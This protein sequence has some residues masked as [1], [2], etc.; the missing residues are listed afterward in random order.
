MNLIKKEIDLNGKTM[1]IETGW[2]AK[3]ANGSAVVRY[4]DTMV[5]VT[6]CASKDAKEGQDFFPLQVEY[7]ER[8]YAAGKIPGGFFKRESRPSEKEILTARCTDRPIRPCFP[9]G[10]L[11]EVQVIVHVISQDQENDADVLAIVGAGTVLSISDIPFGKPV[12]G[13]RVCLVDDQYVVNPTFEQVERSTMDMIVAGTADSI[14]MVEGGSFEISEDQMLKGIA[15][16][17]DAIKKI[18]AAEAELVRECG[19]PKF[20]Y[21]PKTL[22][23]VL[24][25]KVRE[26]SFARVQQCYAIAKKEDR[27]DAV[28]A[29]KK[30]V[31]EKLAAEYPEGAKDIKEVIHGLESDVMRESILSKGVRIDGRATNVIRPIHCQVGVLPRAHGSAL[32]TRGETQGL[33]AATLGTKMDE[34]KIDALHGESWKDYMFHYNFP[35]FC[36]GEVKPIRGTGRREIGHGHLAERSLA[37]VLPSK[38]KFPY[39]IRVVS[40]ILESN[41]S[42]SMASVCGGSLSLMDAGVPLKGPVAGIAMGL[43]KEGDQIAILSDI[44]GDEDHLGDMDF[45]VTGTKDGITAFQ[46][47]IKIAGITPDIMLRALHQARDGR[48]HILGKMAEAIHEPRK[49]LSVYAPRIITL[50][51]GVEEIG[52]IIG[53]QGKVIKD[54]QA[55]TGA[56]IA[57]EDDGTVLIS[58]PGGVGGPEAKA[59]IERIVEKPEIGRI[60]S[61]PVK[62]IKDFGCFVEYL[63]GKEGLVHISELANSRVGKCEDVVTLG[64]VIKVKLVDVDFNTGKVRL[65][66]KQAE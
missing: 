47:D 64:E 33:V 25:A 21:T 62:G 12:A 61:G 58:S 59:L 46:M 8:T 39:T 13:V 38:E 48:L 31:V 44:L 26:L 37:A 43:I 14:L 11:N 20:A 60:Y 16:A 56:T 24:T 23:S 63:P 41:G 36:T 28:A 32:F 55:R 49:D 29:L 51:V 2:W 17:H 6:V 15:A 40:D 52:A 53:P 50:R 54:I 18:C 30:E 45:K 7:R 34:Q 4:G 3:Q 65:S 42:S 5:L 19:K 66:K 57:I 35:P 9:E 22:D 1:T 27:Q 10:F